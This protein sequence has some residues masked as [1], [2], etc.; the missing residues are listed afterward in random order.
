M[1]THAATVLVW[2]RSKQ[3]PPVAAVRRREK[4]DNGNWVIENH[5]NKSQSP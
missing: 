2:R 1:E 4:V 5:F 3:S